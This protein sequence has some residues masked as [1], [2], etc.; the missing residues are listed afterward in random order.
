MAGA[1]LPCAMRSLT[2]GEELDFVPAHMGKRYENWV[3]GL[4]GDWLISRQRFFG[5][6]IPVWYPLDGE[7][8][9]VWDAPIVPS[10]ASSAR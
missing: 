7:G 1:T 4:T 9:I 6:P 8:E 3:L 2:R 10:E 5:V